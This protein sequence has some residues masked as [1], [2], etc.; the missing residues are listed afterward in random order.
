MKII[1][2]PLK[3]RKF[4][5]KGITGGFFLALLLLPFGK[6]KNYSTPRSKPFDKKDK[7]PWRE[8]Q[9][10]LLMIARRYGAEYGDIQERF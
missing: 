8:D 2:E 4:L 5:R 1:N 7:D 6:T 10:R 9:D 3:R